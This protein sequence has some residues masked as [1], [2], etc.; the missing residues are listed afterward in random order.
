MS[1]D[2]R[3]RGLRAQAREALAQRDYSAPPDAERLALGGFA[4]GDVCSRRAALPWIPG[5]E[6]IPRTIYPQRFRGHFGELGRAGEGVL[7]GIGF[8]PAQWASATMHAGSAKGFHIHPPHIPDGEAPETWFARLFGPDT[9]PAQAIALRPYTLEQWDVMFFISGRAEMW[10]VD[11]R[12]GLDHR[13]MR[14][15]IDGD[16]HRS[17]HNAA[18]V[19]PPGVAHAIRSEGSEDLVMVYGTSTTFNPAS[20]GRIAHDCETSTPPEGW[21]AYWSEAH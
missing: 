15:F 5:V 19:I 17:P 3:W 4:A 6:L 21:E 20:E 14:F 18:V 9:D 13:R 2:A 1:T 7:G 10:L 8:W 16:N 11:E 12:A